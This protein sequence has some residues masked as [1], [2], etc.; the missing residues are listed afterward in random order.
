MRVYLNTKNKGKDYGQ[1]KISKVLLWI[2][3]VGLA[4]IM[5]FIIVNFLFNIL[6]Y[7]DFKEIQGLEE[8]TL[9]IKE[10]ISL[11]PLS[12]DPAIQYPNRDLMLYLGLIF[13][14]LLPV[15]S[16][17]FTIGYF[18]FKR[19]IRLTIISVGVLLILAI[20]AI[21]GFILK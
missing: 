9:G 14:I 5:I 15:T 20:S 19:N 21:L 8:N 1:E 16:L 13:L 3:A 4:A 2:L 6:T 7:P 17:F 11:N 18:I 10:L 12:K